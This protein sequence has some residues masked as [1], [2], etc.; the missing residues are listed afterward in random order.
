MSALPLFNSFSG[1]KWVRENIAF[2]SHPLHT[3]R[4]YRAENLRPDLVAG[5]TVA[6]VLLPQAIAYALLAELPP[7]FGIYTAIVGAIF[8]SLWGYSAQMHT[9]PTNT[10]SLLVLSAL[11]P[12]AAPGSPEFLAAAGLMAVMI[13]V[14]Q[15]FMGL[16]RLGVLVNFVSDSV[17]VG[18]AAGA[19]V[20]ITA[21]QLRYLLGL[22]I[23]SVPEFY[24]TIWEVVSHLPQTNWYSLGLGLGTVL[25]VG[26]IK[27]ARPRWPASLIGLVMASA[28]VALLHLDRVGV[29]VLGE[30]PRTL[31]QLTRLPIFNLTLIGKLSTGALAVAAMGLI[32]SLS[33]ARTYAVQS[34]ENLDSNQEFVGQGVANVMSGVFS[35]YVG[36]GSFLLSAVKR[37][38]G[39]HTPFASVFSGVWVLVAVLL[40]APLTVYLP[41]AALAGVLVVTA[42]GMMDRKEMKRIWRAS[43]GDSLIMVAT[44]LATVLLPLEFAVLAGVLVSFVRFI[45][46]TSM[47]SVYSVV[48]SEDYRHLIPS[49]GQTICPQL[50]VITISGPLYFGATHHVESAIREELLTHPAQKLLLLRLHLVDHC[51]VSGIHVLEA[52][53]RFSRQHDGDVYLA[54]VRSA[55]QERMQLAGFDV[56][57]GRE[58]FLKRDE[59]IGYLFY[60]VL[61]PAVCVYQCPFRVFAE[62]QAL[63]KYE[64]SSPVSPLTFPEHEVQTWQVNELKWFLDQEG[65]IPKLTIVDVREPAEYEAGHIPQAQLLP[66]RMVPYQSKN[67]SKDS[68][69]VLVCRTGR[70]SRLAAGIMQ[71]LGFTHVFN[72]EGGILAWEGAGYPVAKVQ[73]TI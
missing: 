39:G 52:I 19:G 32:Q 5:L 33:I 13:G 71:D 73:E 43:L 36:S 4:T 56:Q 55:V 3:L 20:L 44:L 68:A 35:G 9:G 8:G 47:P 59:A 15:I 11:L 49:M 62:C 41:R 53:V 42:L 54:G 58:H 12:L 61:D 27:K 21:N 57:L 65:L 34:G 22:S 6:A 16:A 51:D 66:M 69:L 60:H 64:F 45:V 37:E 23:P 17:I 10:L 63:P 30:L 48:P 29:S 40:L 46:K 72:L 18:F 25:V 1:Q 24:R 14:A 31:P 67:F 38:N 70:R 7:Q 2:F 28:L 50:A 26:L